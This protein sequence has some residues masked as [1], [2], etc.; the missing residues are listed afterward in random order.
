M[1]MMGTC[2][3]CKRAQFKFILLTTFRATVS[4]E[5]PHIMR[6]P[7][8]QSFF[9]RLSLLTVESNIAKEN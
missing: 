2:F 5:K 1:V 3:F 9:R 8:R 7:D 6:N 4:P